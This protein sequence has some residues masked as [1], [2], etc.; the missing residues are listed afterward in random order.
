MAAGGDRGQSGLA[1]GDLHRGRDPEPEAAVVLELVQGLMAEVHPHAAPIA[2]TLDRKFED[3]LGLASLELVE[4]LLRVEDAFGVALPSQVLAISETPRDIVRAVRSAQRRPAF[5]RPVTPSP[6]V[7]GAVSAPVGAST[8]VEALDWHV[9]S[10]PTRV[11]IRILDESGVADELTY[12]DLYRQATSVAAGLQARDVGRGDTVAIMLPTSRSYFLTFAGVLL[13]GGIPV[14]IYPPA[15]PAQLADHLRRHVS[16]LANAATKVLVTVPEAIPLGRLLRSQVE[17]LRDVVAPEPMAALAKSE[18]PVAGAEDVALLQYTSGSTGHPKGV[19]L[20]HDNLLANIRAMGQAVAASSTDTF[21]SWLPLYHDM[22]LIGAWLASLYFGMP[23]AVM[24]PQVFL[25]RPSRW[26]R[27]IQANGGT[28]SAGPNFAYEL[29]VNKIGEAELE[30]LDLASWRLAFSG[31]EPVSPET[32]ERFTTRFVPYGLRRE[33]I[34]PVY[35]LAESSVG[36]TFPPLGRGPLVDSIDRQVF[37]RS[38]RAV[39]ASNAEPDALRFVACGQPLAGHELRVVDAAGNELGDRE[40]GG[41]E[42]RGPSAT[43]GYYRNAEATRSLFHG[44]WLDTG[45][46]GYVAG[47]ET[48]V[49][50]RLKDVV[51]RAGRNLHPDELEESVGN[52]AGVRKG[53]VVVFASPD[54]ATGTERLVVVAETR[55]TE[56]EALAH[57]RSEILGVT[58]DLLGTPPDD[59][60][61]ARPRAV[62]KTS[63]GKIRR[64]ASRERYELGTIGARPKSAW[65][66]VARFGLSGAMPGLRRARRRMAAVAFAGYAWALLVAV[67]LPT[68]ALLGCVPGQDRRWRLARL[69]VRLLARLTGTPVSVRGLDRLPPGPSLVVANHPSWLD[70][71]VLAMVLPPSL[72]FVAGELFA[73]QALSGFVLRRVGAEF[74]ERAEREQSVTDTDRLVALAQGGRQLVLFPEGRLARAPGLRSF[75]IGAFVVAVRAGVPVVPVAIRG[76]RSMLRP[77]HRFPRRGAIQVVAEDPIQ[78]KGTDWAAAVELQQAARAVVLRHCGEQDLE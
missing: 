17:S 14:P 32:I 27:A 54:P 66:Q 18:L 5:H 29:C 73:R 50:G 15:R 45:D 44:D 40:E 75:H 24:P 9:G 20:T 4:L 7:T 64:A 49:T 19:V 59:V 72:H 25:A 3:E 38:G 36:L 30:G 42:F 23:L 67:A 58:V 60:V 77:G 48:Y 13:A 52:L 21:V 61:L 12:D 63:S 6:R 8:L 11:H 56:E 55:E 51:I 1:T 62:L 37:L 22:G 76:T 16:I 57:L 47:G 78:P 28:I 71:L 46:L 2:L 70:S 69:A 43:S 10:T 68:F 74:V 65:R 33:A 31:A 39:P 34:T 26:L 41:I 53:C 35:G